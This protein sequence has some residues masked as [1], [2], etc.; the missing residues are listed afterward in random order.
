MLDIKHAFIFSLIV[1]LVGIVIGFLIG[2]IFKSDLPSV[3][4]KWNKNH[5]MEI[6]LLLTGFFSYLVFTLLFPKE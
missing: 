2:Q 5:V 3:C 1:L 4:K 6:S